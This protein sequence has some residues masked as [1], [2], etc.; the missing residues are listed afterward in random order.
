MFVNVSADCRRER[1]KRQTV[2]ALDGGG[3]FFDFE[4]DHVKRSEREKK[5]YGP[6]AQT[7][8]STPIAGYPLGIPVLPT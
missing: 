2:E 7:R 6:D 4:I 8:I 3:G 1:E 5:P